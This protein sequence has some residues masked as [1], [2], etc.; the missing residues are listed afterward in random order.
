MLIILWWFDNMWLIKYKNEW[1]I[2]V[3]VDRTVVA[4]YKFMKK[5]ASVPFNL[6]KPT[7]N[8][9]KE[10]SEIDQKDELRW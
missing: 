1:Q 2:T 8:D 5:H 6:Q 4:L 9:A 3:D 10:S 7:Y